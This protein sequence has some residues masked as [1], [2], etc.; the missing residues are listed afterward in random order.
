MTL[1]YRLYLDACCLNRPFDDQRQSRIAL[2]T[3]AILAIL[4]RCQSGQWQLMSSTALDT[5]LDQTPNRERLANMKAMLIIAKI[6]VLS[7]QAIETRARELKRLGFSTYDAVHIASAER[8]RADVFI[9]TDDRLIKRAVQNIH[10]LR[11]P[12]DNPVSWL[13]QSTLQSTQS[14]GND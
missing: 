2:E 11:V 13:I 5:E 7:S 8:G 9:S 12:V 14:E 4:S 3:Q 10:L 6:K 1:N